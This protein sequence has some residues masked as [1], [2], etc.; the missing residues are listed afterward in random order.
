MS[1]L[2]TVLPNSWKVP[3]AVKQKRMQACLNCEFLE[4]GKTCGPFLTGKAVQYN[5]M[6]VKLCGCLVNEKTELPSERCPLPKWTE[7]TNPGL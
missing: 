5:F 6:P 3:P 4:N 2:G 1:F 7:Y